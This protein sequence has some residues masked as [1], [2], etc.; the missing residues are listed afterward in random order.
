MWVP[1]LV[2]SPLGRAI[3]GWLGSG[4]FVALLWCYFWARYFYSRF[5]ASKV[6]GSKSLEETLDGM[7]IDDNLTIA[8]MQRLR[9]LRH[10]QKGRMRPAFKQL[11]GRIASLDL[12][13]LP[14]RMRNV[15]SV[16]DLVAAAA[17]PAVASPRTTSLGLG[18]A[19]GGG[20]SSSSSS[21][22]RW[23]EGEQ[24]MAA[25]QLPTVASAIEQS[26]AAALPS[27]VRDAALFRSI[28]NVAEQRQLA[29]DG[30]A[31]ELCVRGERPTLA[32]VI[33][34][35][36]TV[37]VLASTD[38]A[39]LHSGLSRYS[40]GQSVTSLLTTLYALSGQPVPLSVR[41]KSVGDGPAQL[42]VLPTAAYVPLVLGH[43][44]FLSLTV[45]ETLGRLDAGLLEVAAHL[46]LAP[47]LLQP[48][49]V[50]R[51]CWHT[52]ESAAAIS[53]QMLVFARATVSDSLGVPLSELPETDVRADGWKSRPTLPAAV[54][55][56]ALLTIRRV[57]AGFARVPPGSLLVVLSGEL[58]I[59]R[60]AVAA[61]T[62]HTGPATDASFTAASS[63]T[64]A[65][66]GTRWLQQ[67]GSAL[68]VARE[69]EVVG[70][71]GTL[72]G[73][74]AEGSRQFR[75]RA[76]AGP[77]WVVEVPAEVFA[78]CVLD[79]PLKV[80]RL[81][82]AARHDTAVGRLASLGWRLDYALMYRSVR[83]HTVL[84]E[85]G[86]AAD[87]LH[88]VMSGR[89]RGDRDHMEYMRGSLIGTAELLDDGQ[90]SSTVVA[91][92]DSLLAQLP[93]ALFQ[94][95]AASHP[96]VLAHICR[97]MA[98]RLLA[99]RHG[100]APT[101]ASASASPFTGEGLD[102][103]KTIA[104]LP[105]GEG[106]SQDEL[107]LFC[108]TLAT[109]VGAIRSCR[110]ID[111]TSL[112]IDLPL[113][114]SAHH[115]E[116][117]LVSWLGEQEE[118]ARLIIYQADLLNTS[119]SRRCV[120][121]ADLVLRLANPSSFEASSPVTAMET[122]LL[123]GVIARQE[124]VL[125]HV[126]PSKSYRPTHT[127]S[128][129][130]VRAPHVKAHH[131]IR[132]HT[133]DGNE[134]SPIG[135]RVR[136]RGSVQWDR[137]DLRSDFHRLA[138]HVCKCSVGLVLG[139]GG[140]RGMAHLST[141]RAMEEQ[142]IPIDKIGGTSIGSFVG[143]IYAEYQDW[144][145]T[146][147]RSAAISSVLGSTIGY[148]KDLTCPL[149]SL[150]TARGMNTGLRE[151]FGKDTRIE[152]LWLP[153][154]CITAN[155][156]SYR[157]VVHDQGVLWRYVRASMSL[158]GYLPPLCETDERGNVSLLMDG[159]Y[160]N[161]LPSDVMRTTGAGC[162]IAVDVGG[163]TSVTWDD[164]GDS[165]SGCWLLYTRVRASLLGMLP[166]PVWQCLR[167]RRRPGP[168]PAAP[169]IM[170]MGEI[171]GELA[172]LMAAQ[173]ARETADDIDL[174]LV[175][176]VQEYRTLDFHLSDEILDKGYTYATRQ[177]GHW[178]AG[179]RRA[180]AAEGAVGSGSRSS[181]EGQEQD[182]FAI[183]PAPAPA[184]A[185]APGDTGSVDRG[186]AKAAQKVASDH[187]AAVRQD[188]ANDLLLDYERQLGIAQ[189]GDDPNAGSTGELQGGEEVF[190]ATGSRDAS[191]HAVLSDYMVRQ[192]QQ[193][194]KVSRK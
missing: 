98:Q 134:L 68:V 115:A 21:S 89:L 169:R 182:P 157:E 176:P 187:K 190:A 66:K 10:T 59:H 72:S 179:L 24:A 83:A 111:S 71:L 154:Y 180:A 58:G 42:L 78:R 51:G 56:H 132:L 166:A 36:G 147:W 96:V 192:Q 70:L 109:A 122:A 112:K 69:G 161:N 34:L 48:A 93:A 13:G 159:G 74:S 97:T 26:L 54:P 104:V 110:V 133:T 188:T 139:G 160:L 170:S 152:D 184:P 129:L 100:V 20:R 172:F 73:E 45:R 65:H 14:G 84:L 79:S 164:F 30:P 137:Y 95:V 61:E 174:L 191:V 126:D 178:R 2:G 87:G 27:A 140:A 120:R 117:A 17:T 118:T 46:G 141:I 130:S 90:M 55:E 28:C 153:Y 186:K 194:A 156:A 193:Q 49:T 75:P 12:R 123:A 108:S 38:D 88:V 125:L 189:R 127:R 124:L 173:R 35:E 64:E 163:W 86:H 80:S 43:R 114:L 128:W 165:L 52:V 105:T 63:A 77:C 91:V 116:V 50:A 15:G 145:S 6:V 155:V 167:C 138:R 148:V 11:A 142:G 150:F 18:L 25:R 8:S 158:Q 85:R 171:S 31:L 5:E 76:A 41:V 23:E 40:A 151:I 4:V 60:R 47:S 99:Q 103:I 81:L 101:N 183:V 177:L 3:P 1:P 143:A 131:H 146:Q 121:Q 162:V 16:G 32:A 106:L 29:A 94:D 19:M 82:C 144:K 39:D 136:G 168:P 149:V 113:D 37:E 92:R 102:G 22:S 62:E 44:I 175:P 185:P 107:D 57:G 119:W 53:T 7:S 33:V 135:N 67:H 9:K 181:Q